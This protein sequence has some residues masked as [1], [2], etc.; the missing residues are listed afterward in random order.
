MRSRIEH[1]EV[2]QLV[3]RY[4]RI[5]NIWAT[6]GAVRGP[7]RAP[8]SDHKRKTLEAAAAEILR[9]LAHL[10]YDIDRLTDEQT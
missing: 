2:R 9:E 8:L 4:K 7:Y 5:R 3:Y 6:N 10:G 1:N